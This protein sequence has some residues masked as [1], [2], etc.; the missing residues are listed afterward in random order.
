MSRDRST[1]WRRLTVL[2]N[3][4]TSSRQMERKNVIFRKE[5]TGDWEQ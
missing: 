4:L 2:S 1:S 3:I 5:K